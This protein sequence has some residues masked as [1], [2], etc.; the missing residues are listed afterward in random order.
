VPDK[1]FAVSG[2]APGLFCA[3][4][5][6]MPRPSNSKVPDRWSV[7]RNATWRVRLRPGLATTFTRSPA[8]SVVA[9]QPYC[10]MDDG[11]KSSIC[12][13]RFSPDVV[14]SCSDRYACGLAHSNPA[15][16]PSIVTCVA[17]S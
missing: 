14:V 5:A 17:M 11:E 15:T 2:G 6:P 16:V 12:Q 9:V 4:A 7:C 13:V 8:A 10:F 3:G 1:L